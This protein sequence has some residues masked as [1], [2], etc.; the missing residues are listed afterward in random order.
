MCV[1]ANVRRQTDRQT[2][3]WVWEA[4]EKGHKHMHACVQ[5]KPGNHLKRQARCQGEE[6]AQA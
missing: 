2:D 5:R 6:K 4:R 1:G 3:L